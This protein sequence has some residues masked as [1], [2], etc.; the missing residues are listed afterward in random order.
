MY[1]NL[2]N[3]VATPVIRRLPVYYRKLSDCVEQGR[4]R[5]SSQELSEL[6][7]FSASQIRQDLN[8]FGGFGQQGYGYNTALLRDE[9][10]QILGIHNRYKAVV[11]GAGRLGTAIFEYEGIR[12]SGFDIVALF[13]NDPKKIG[14]KVEHV[15]IEPADELLHY[16]DHHQVDVAII[17]V[18]KTAAEEIIRRLD[19]H[20][21][22]GIWNFAPVDVNVTH[23]IVENTR[24]NDSILKLSY[25]LQHGR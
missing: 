2:K 14:M 6:C 5:I 11:V 7:G 19:A 22:R 17:T 23:S 24:I 12:K 3:K 15:T 8:H 4:D 13:D 16:I 1:K 10:A 21:I 25:Y 20:G 9:I 18:P